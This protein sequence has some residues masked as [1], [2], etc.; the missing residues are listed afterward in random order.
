MV[1]RFA[2]TPYGHQSSPNRSRFFS[3]SCL[4][5][6]TVTSCDLTPNRRAILHAVFRLGSQA[7]PSAVAVAC[8]ISKQA[9]SKHLPLLRL[10]GLLLPSGGATP[11]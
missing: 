5:H 9:V 4:N 7:T 2:S 10:R 8:G 1:L 3:L 11:R 6:G